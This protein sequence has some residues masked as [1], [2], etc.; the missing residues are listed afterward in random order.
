MLRNFIK[1]IFS[2]NILALKSNKGLKTHLM[3]SGLLLALAGFNTPAIADLD[4]VDRAAMHQV[5]KQY[6]MDNPEVVRDAL[7]ELAAREK[8]AIITAG[9]KKLRRDDGD[10]VMGNVNGSLVIY[11]FSDYN[12]GYCKRMFPTIQQLLAKNDDIRLVVKEFP[13]LSQSSLIAARAGVAAQKQGKFR[14]FH[15]EM[16][17]Y[18][19]QV[20]EATI[21]TAARTAQLDL[22]QLRR[23]MDSPATNAIIDRTRDSAAALDLNGTPAL[24]VGETIIPGAVSIEK[25]QN[26]IN[27]ERAKQG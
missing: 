20:S 18:R 24:V 10:P 15:R 9:L 3:L 19:G 21:M 7:M 17:I 27:R 26:V 11:E 1:T 2:S 22:K 16:M 4:K 14:A 5:I 8:Q 23:D 13:I 12:C 25:L 6:I